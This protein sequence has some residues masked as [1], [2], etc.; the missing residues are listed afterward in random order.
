MAGRVWMLPHTTPGRRTGGCVAR[1]PG[2]VGGGRRSCLL[3][4]GSR[5]PGTRV[6][7]AEPHRPE[8]APRNAALRLVLERA[9]EAIE[10]SF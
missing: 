7:P 6:R 8:V 2:V 3:G 9:F 5:L 10:H 4:P 1:R